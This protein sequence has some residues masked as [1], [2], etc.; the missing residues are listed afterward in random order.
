MALD[1]V[2]IIVVFAVFA[3]FIGLIKYVGSGDNEEK[4]GE[5][6]KIMV[7]GIVGFFFMVGVWGALRIF[8]QSYGLDLVIPQLTSSGPFDAACK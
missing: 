8:V 3:F 1:F 5:G 4:R 6:R 7:Y 2:P